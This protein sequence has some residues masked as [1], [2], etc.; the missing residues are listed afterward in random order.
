MRVQMNGLPNLKFPVFVI[1]P[2]ALTRFKTPRDLLR[3]TERFM[4]FTFQDAD[5]LDSSGR[6]HKV[7][8]Y[9]KIRRSLNPLDWFAPSG[10]IFRISIDLGEA[11]PLPLDEAKKKIR[12]LVLTKRWL[13]GT[14]W[15]E[16]KFLE[17]LQSIRSFDELLANF[18]YL[19]PRF[20]AQD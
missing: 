6:L 17:K 18:S 2:H 10:P 5:L 15:S 9:S 19:G 13:R 20:D 4:V 12:E 3:S 7:M 14:H 11:H 8:H 16:S 1:G